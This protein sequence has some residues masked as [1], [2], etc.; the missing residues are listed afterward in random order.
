MVLDYLIN[1]QDNIEIVRDRIGY[2]LLEEVAN[3]QTL[4]T[5]EG[6]DPDD[7]KMRIFVEAF[8]PIEQF[9]NAPTDTSPLIDIWYDNDTFDLSA[10]N[11][12]NRQKTDA[13]YNI[14]CYGY[15]ESTET[16]EGHDPGDRSAALESARAARL[17][18]N[19]LMATDNIYLGLRKI[20]W[21]RWLLTRNA[22]QPERGTNSVQKVLGTRLRFGVQLNETV[23]EPSLSRLNYVAVDFHRADNGQLYFSH[24]FDYS[25]ISANAGELQIFGAANLTRS[26]LLPA[27]KG[28]LQISGAANLIIGNTIQANAGDLRISGAAD[29]KRDLLL[30]ANKGDLQISGAADFKRALLLTA[31]AAGLQVSGEANFVLENIL[32]ANAGD[33]RIDGAADL[34]RSLLLSANKGDLRIS[35]AADFTFGQILEANAGDLRISGAAEFK[36][37]LI[38]TANAGALQISGEAD[39]ILG[40]KLTANAGDLRIDGSADL[41]RALLL[42]ANK[43]DLQI[44]GAADLKRDLLLPAN[45]GDLRIDGAADLKRSLLLSANK[46]DLQIDGSADLNRSLLLSSNKGD[47]RISGEANFVSE[48]TIE[49]NAG[50]LRIDGAASLKRALLLSA[51][52]GD[53]RISGEA[54]FVTPVTVWFVDPTGSGD[55]DGTSWDD[56]YGDIPSAVTAASSGDQIWVKEGTYA[57]TSPITTKANVP[58]YGGFASTLTGTSGSVAG[59]DLVNDISVIDANSTGRIWTFVSNSTIDGFTCQEGSADGGGAALIDTL[60]GILI[61]NV[62]FSSCVSTGTSL[63]N[64]GGALN[65]DTSEVTLNDCVIDS[66]TSTSGGYGGGIAVRDENGGVQLNDCTISNCDSTFGGGMSINEGSSNQTVE[67]NRCTF[68]SN[69]ASGGTTN[70]GG[71][72]INRAPLADFYECIFDSNSATYYGGCLS[73]SLGTATTNLTD[74]RITSHSGRTVIQVSGDT[75]MTSCIVDSS[76]TSG[77]AASVFRIAAATLETINCT[78]TDN[79]ESGDNVYRTASSSAV[80]TIT[81]TICYGNIGFSG[82][83]YDGGGTITVTYSDIEDGYTGTGNINSDPDFLDSG[84]DPYQIVSGSPCIDAGDGDAAPTLDIL[85]NTRYDDPGT[86][87]TGTGTPAYTDIGAYE[88]QGT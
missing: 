78:V 86:T 77:F 49:A 56:A 44:D 27:N 8:N 52:K 48:N 66:C 68:D 1:K 51:N 15:G 6:L 14:D 63:F 4:A 32:P 67:C 47:L 36:R 79:V 10:S 53:L 16:V 69:D 34:K 9:L 25:A 20:V 19:I 72:F 70:Q 35:G 76:T 83:I 28:D 57:I 64:G 75:T 37:A 46:G 30:P 58:I 74:C 17:V 81:N 73:T 13:V 41:K 85:G 24:D 43:G 55:E 3:Q 65:I 7:Y 2:I 11:V 50:D 61:E 5:A 60:T 45:A 87:N 39:L 80:L 31:N 29:F 40:Q 84:D 33:L 21:R 62:K 23:Q 54:N 82:Q 26:L 59:R 71:A 38:L 12:S 22:F 18:R 42:S 88:Y